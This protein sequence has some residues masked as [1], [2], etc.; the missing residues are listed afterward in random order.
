MTRDNDPVPAQPSS[1]AVP[2][3]QDGAVAAEASGAVPVHSA[4]PAPAVQQTAVG[5]DVP[6]AIVRGTAQ[7]A[8]QGAS[9]TLMACVTEKVLADPPDWLRTLWGL[10]KGLFE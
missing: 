3:Q 7:G 2:A 8:A 9:K 1:D 10:L 6:A 5:A 4:S